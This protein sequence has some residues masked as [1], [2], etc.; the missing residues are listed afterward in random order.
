MLSGFVSA[1]G[2]CADCSIIPSD[3]WWWDNGETTLNNGTAVN[4]DNMVDQGWLDRNGGAQLCQN[5][6]YSTDQA[7]DG[8]LSM[9]LNPAGS[10]DRGCQLP[11]INEFT[12]YVGLIGWWVYYPASMD[13]IG[14]IDMRNTDGSAHV[15]GY[16][17]SIST[18][19]FTYGGVVA[20]SEN[21]QK[22]VW[23]WCYVNF[24]GSD[25][26]YY[27]NNNYLGNYKNGNIN[28]FSIFAQSGGGN[29]RTFFIDGFRMTKNGTKSFPEDTTFNVT[30]IYPSGVVDNSRNLTYNVTIEMNNCTLFG[31]F[32]G[33][34]E[35]DQL[36]L[37]VSNTTNHYF[38]ING[39]DYGTYMWNV[40]CFDS[41]SNEY[42]AERNLTFA[43][44]SDTDEDGIFDFEDN[45]PFVFNPN[46]TNIDEDNFGEAC[47]CNDH[48]ESVYPP[49]D[50][51]NISKSTTFC[52]GTYYLP[53]GISINAN[54]V[55]LD[56]DNAIL[57][58]N[59]SS[60]GTNGIIIEN[61]NEAAIKN[62]EVIKYEN[63]VYL[64]SSSNNIVNNNN[65]H[66][67]LN[68]IKL[69][70]DSFN[71]L[72]IKYNN[73]YNN[74]NYNL[75]NNNINDIYAKYNYWGTNI[76]SEIQNNI[77]DYNDNPTKGTVIYK[78]WQ[79]YPIVDCT[80]PTDEMV[81]TSDT[82]FCKGTYYLYSG[83][84]IGANNIT[85]NCDDSVLIGND[86]NSA[87]IASN[88]TGVIVKNCNV[89]NYDNGI[90]LSQV[91]YSII[92]NNKAKSNNFFQFNCD[93]CKEVVFKDNEAI[94][95]TM[96]VGYHIIHSSN[97]TLESNKAMKN[98]IGLLL[99]YS[100]NNTIEYNNISY[101]DIGINI[102]YD[103]NRNTLWNNY[104][105][106]NS[107]FGLR[108]QL[109]AKDNYIW[110]N[111][112]YY[113]GVYNETS[114][115]FC[116]IGNKYFEEATGP[117]CLESCG[118]GYDNDNDGF[119]DECREYEVYC[120]NGIDEDN[121]GLI[122]LGD[123]D[124]FSYNVTVNLVEGWNLVASPYNTEINS[125]EALTSIEGC[126]K[127]IFG[128]SQGIWNS[129]VPG[130]PFSN[131]DMIRPDRGYWININCTQVN[132]T[133]T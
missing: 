103:S 82:K 44:S 95:S 1:L 76:E 131:I 9:R 118:D 34:W 31:N 22:D 86:A 127:G 3:Y 36:E 113:T 111:L 33:M 124:C 125:T 35:S 94:N 61:K 130:N 17:G 8:T 109:N 11:T 77:Y 117:I 89:L 110:N 88:K 62:C 58:G 132:W 107:Q 15:L 51:M 75:Y 129:L 2:D 63:G 97:L 26:L 70:S 28:V 99:E 133:I 39:F 18:T 126:Y 53:S 73:L 41:L 50:G 16:R 60:I 7:K 72:T 105:Y 19:K 6:V 96:N 122:D 21:I 81:I 91:K 46:Q 120:D 119:V 104:F 78:P 65:I 14:G 80:V 68:G 98:N 45:C 47:D 64:L 101:N 13:S 42:W 4:N 106:N 69:S 23:V 102:I 52:P 59:N 30:L 32:T 20:S 79:E 54:N 100:M 12:G 85:L 57:N 84:S 123:P 29:G 128:F 37:T 83:I 49:V 40:Q 43:L 71:G 108:L 10:T 93:Y 27:A 112:F 92:E 5:A 25:I 56:C 55:T 90:D 115:D 74:T 121:D 116:R 48:D 67:N 87:I 24:T 114:N 38:N 66:S